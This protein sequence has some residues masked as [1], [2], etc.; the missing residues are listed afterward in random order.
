MFE[1]LLNYHMCVFVFYFL[2]IR[3]YNANLIVKYH[4]YPINYCS[5][6]IKRKRSF[7]KFYGTQTHF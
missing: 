3:V 1:N 2:N 6:S 5:Y 7:C 4:S